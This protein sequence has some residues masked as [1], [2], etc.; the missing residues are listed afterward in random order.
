MDAV[1]RRR[2]DQPSTDFRL[3]LQILEVLDQLHTDSLKHIVAVGRRKAKLVRDREDQ[4]ALPHDQSFPSLSL[5]LQTTRNE[6]WIGEFLVTL[7]LHF[8]IFLAF[9]KL[10]IPK[11][12][13]ETVKM[14][15]STSAK[16]P[17]SDSVE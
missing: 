11:A 12:S 13:I 3:I 10:W 5:T 8:R 2:R 15:D 14:R 6:F 9:Q 4:T 16:D 7:G 17:S 1:A